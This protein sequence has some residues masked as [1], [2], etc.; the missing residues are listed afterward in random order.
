MPSGGVLTDHGG[1]LP[2]QKGGVVVPNRAEKHTCRGFSQLIRYDSSAFESFPTQFEEQSLLRVDGYGFS[3]RYS[4]ECRI[5]GVD[6]VE[7]ST[8][9]G[10]HLTRRVPLESE[11]RVC[12]PTRPWHDPDSVRCVREQVPECLGGRCLGKT[13]RH[14]DDGNRFIVLA[15]FEFRTCAALSTSRADEVG[16]ALGCRAL[17][18]EHRRKRTTNVA[19][20]LLDKLRRALG[21]KTVASK[22]LRGIDLPRLESEVMGKPG[23]DE[24]KVFL[25]AQAACPA[26]RSLSIKDDS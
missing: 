25:R 21:I 4:K 1:T 14:A 23:D 5:K 10:V 16:Q 3:W 18:Y 20:K 6:L 15:R 13:T 8:P 9:A 26:E 12:I 19:P 2:I 22:T 17:P 24:P 7:K 11:P